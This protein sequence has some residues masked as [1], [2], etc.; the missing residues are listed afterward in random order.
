VRY[1]FRE[2]NPKRLRSRD[3]L[4]VS[5]DNNRTSQS[6]ANFDSHRTCYSMVLTLS[7]TITHYCDHNHIL[8]TSTLSEILFCVVSLYFR[9]SFFHWLRPHLIVSTARY[10]LRKRTRSQLIEENNQSDSTESDQS[11][12]LLRSPIHTRLRKVLFKLHCLISL[13]GKHQSK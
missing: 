10:L 3:S 9:N 6:E 4:S 2:R 11:E 8:T 7:H 12:H 1:N 5:S 13:K